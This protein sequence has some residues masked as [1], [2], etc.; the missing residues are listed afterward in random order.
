M[1]PSRYV[2]TVLPDLRWLNYAWQPVTVASY[3]QR[4]CTIQEL[5]WQ[6]RPGLKALQ[7]FNVAAGVS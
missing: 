6:C 2:V 3:V 5:L 1:L 4:V 7:I